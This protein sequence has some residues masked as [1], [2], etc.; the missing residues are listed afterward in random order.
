MQSTTDVVVLQEKTGELQSQR[1][2]SSGDLEPSTFNST[3]FNCCSGDYM[4]TWCCRWGREV[5]KHGDGLTHYYLLGFVHNENS[6][7]TFEK[8]SFRY[9]SFFHNSALL[10]TSSSLV[11][12]S[13]VLFFR[14]NTN[15]WLKFFIPPVRSTVG[16]CGRLIDGRS[17][18]PL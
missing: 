17:S 13:S 18:V 4:Y 11:I 14:T 9:W 1:D 12:S 7:T 3:Y 8:K 15:M 6:E 10:K 5:R 2:S 16:V